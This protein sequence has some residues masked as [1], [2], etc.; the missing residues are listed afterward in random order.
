[1]QRISYQS[2][3]DDNTLGQECRKISEQAEQTITHLEIFNSFF[4]TLYNDGKHSFS[5]A[6]FVIKPVSE[7][8]SRKNIKPSFVKLTINKLRH[9]RKKTSE[10][11]Q[12]QN[13]KKKNSRL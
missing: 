6:Y 5:T 9:S 1:M 4:F 7:T 13:Q 3:T 12:I 11:K 2:A 10:L 8:Y